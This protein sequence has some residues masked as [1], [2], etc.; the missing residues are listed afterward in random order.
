M[1]PVSK[2]QTALFLLV[3]VGLLAV[4]CSKK[5]N[6]NA[7]A[8]DGKAAKAVAAVS[9]TDE[10]AIKE[11]MA[12][13]QGPKAPIKGNLTPD[14]AAEITNAVAKVSLAEIPS[15]DLPKD[16]KVMV[17]INDRIRQKSDAIY[18]QYGTT[19]GDVMRYISDLSPQEREKYNKK[20]TDLFL[21]DSKK[22]ADN[23]PVEKPA[24]MAT[25]APA[26]VKEVKAAKPGKPAK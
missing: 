12:T 17:E 14:K 3:G 24:P 10:K 2:F 15:R 22:R 6:D 13:L 16:P 25:A 23:A 19:M 18:S 9:R 26:D 8:L 11:L 7:A 4:G 1:I 5:T 20:L 21:E